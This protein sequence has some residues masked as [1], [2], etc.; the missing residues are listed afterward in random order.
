MYY[1]PQFLRSEIWK[2]LGRVFL[3]QGHSWTYG[4]AISWGFI[5]GRIEWSWKC[6]FQGILLMW[7][8]SDGLHSLSS[9][10]ESFSSSP[11]GLFHRALPLGSRLF[12]KWVMQERGWVTKLGATVSFSGFF[13]VYLFYWSIVDLQCCVNCCYTAKWFRYI[14]VCVYIYNIYIYILFHYGL[15][16][17]IV[18]SS[19]CYTVG[20]CCLSIYQF[21]FA[22]PKLPIH[23]SSIPTPPWQPQICSLCSQ[24]W[25]IITYVTCYWIWSVLIEYGR[26]LHKS[27]NTRRQRSL[28]AIF[29]AAFHGALEYTLLSTYEDSFACG[30]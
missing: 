14:Y 5:T 15:S 27:V 8:L 25:F 11:C 16:Q 18:Y 7:L 4:K 6:C 28:R 26:E 19:L 13:W 22:N 17:D 30:L 3:A 29:G 9:F 10:P 1:L 21:A 20:P 24:K 12:P 2:W 23:P